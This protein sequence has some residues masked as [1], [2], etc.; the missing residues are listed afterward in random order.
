MRD[1]GHGEPAELL[2][3]K[4]RGVCESPDVSIYPRDNKQDCTLLLLYCT[5]GLHRSPRTEAVMRTVCTPRENGSRLV[6]IYTV[7]LL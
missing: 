7:S 3:P 5:C 6:H 1:K 2:A 4:A